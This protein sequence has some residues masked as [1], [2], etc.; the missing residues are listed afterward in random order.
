MLSYQHAYHAGGAAD[1]H[2]HLALATLLAP[3]AGSGA[4][5]LE[6][7]A[8]RGLYDLATAEA[9]KTGEA[10]TGLG[11]LASAFP[12]GP[13]SGAL[14]DV[15]LALRAR[16]GPSAYPGS[17]A[18]AASLL[19]REDRL[20]LHE[21][22]PAEYA[23]LRYARPRLDAFGRGKAG[24]YVEVSR[25]DGHEALRSVG[26]DQ[27]PGVAL[28]DPSYEVKEEFAETAETAARLAEAWPAGV[29][30]VWYPILPAGRHEAMA[31]HLSAR[32]GER[33]RRHEAS[34]VD[35]PARGMRGSGLLLIG[36]PRAL[37][38]SLLDA[39]SPCTPILRPSPF[40]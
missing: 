34:F 10:E 32:L 37:E 20:V 5:Y 33:C 36:L 4:L 21:R 35:P 29:V 15:L 2:K 26:P 1:L 9:A 38:P 18:V 25:E 16:D 8:G 11:R 12:E 24:P 3:L 13:P 27:R 31:E 6:S 23:A 7:H 30:M 40:R 17:P 19:R 14:W 22:H 39:W 28:I